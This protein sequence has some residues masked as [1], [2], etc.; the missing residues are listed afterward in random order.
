MAHSRLFDGVWRAGGRTGFR[1][2]TCVTA[3]IVEEKE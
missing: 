1:V 2:L 3:L